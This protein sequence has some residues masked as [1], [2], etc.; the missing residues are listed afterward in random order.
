MTTV[1]LGWDG[2]DRDRALDWG[3]A[4]RFG[5]HHRE[6]EVYDN[7][8]LGKP[9]TYE[10]WPSML[11][12]LSRDA[13]G[14]DAAD[15]M[16]GESWDSTLLNAAARLSRPLPDTVRERV[17][18]W[19]RSAGATMAFETEAYYTDLPTVFDGVDGVAI[20]IPNYHSPT[21]RAV[22]IDHDR[23]ATLADFLQFG[24]DGEKT[25]HR[26]DIP[27]N[28][29]E[30]RLAATVGQKLAVAQQ[31]ILQGV[32]LVWVWLGYLDT[33]GHLE[34]VID[35]EGWLRRHYGLAADWTDFLRSELG[36]ADTLVS[37]SDHGL[38]EGAHRHAAYIGSHDER[39][40]ARVRDVTDVRGAVERVTERSGSAA[41]ADTDSGA[42][43]ATRDRL[44]S[45]GYLPTDTGN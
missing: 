12:G 17:G 3:L 4:S 7:P 25:Q 6:L 24:S 9:H 45:L 21:D 19:V 31:A 33:L 28:E 16:A 2:L 8:A 20:G 10:L 26:P 41:P 29:L 36:A 1:V 22:G 43:A 37:V 32:D 15:Y 13:H 42:A 39:V 14:I 35:S 18:R 34:P 40:C 27:V 5:S 23:A 38:R 11:T 44:A 30:Q